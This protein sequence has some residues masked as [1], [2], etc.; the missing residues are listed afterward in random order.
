M[1]CRQHAAAVVVGSSTTRSTARVSPSG[2][3][4]VNGL[5]LALVTVAVMQVR[6]AGHAEIAELPPLLHWLRDAALALPLALA[7]VSV[8]SWL[9]P[10]AHRAGAPISERGLWVLTGGAVWALSSVPAA[11]AHGLLF[12]EHSNHGLAKHGLAMHALLEGAAVLGVAL[13]LLAV[14]AA[15]E[16]LW[17]TSRSVNLVRAVNLVRCRAAVGG[18]GASALVAGQL[19]VAVVAPTPAA[20]S[21][22][23]CT[24]TGADRSYDVTAATVDI[25][26]NR[27]GAHVQGSMF[28][29]S[30]DL[31]AV[32]NWSVPLAA[33]PAADVAGGRRLRPRPLVLRANAGECV[34]V[35]LHNE[36]SAAA[37]A[38]MP[39]DPHVSIHPQGVA[40]NVDSDGSATG[41]NPDSTVALHGTRTYLWTAPSKEGMYL[42][43]DFGVPGGAEHDAGQ[44]G[45]G[46]FGALNVEPAGSRWFDP[47]SGAELSLPGSQVYGDAKTRAQSGEL[48]VDAD[49]V[50]PAPA[51]TFR[52]STQIAQDEIPGVG[53]GFNYGS[54]PLSNRE[55][56]RCPD[57][58]GEETWL[59]SWPYGDPALIKLASGPGPWIPKEYGAASTEGPNGPEDCGLPESC[60]VSNVFHAYNSD[61]VKIRFGLAGVKETHVFHLHAHQWLAEPRDVG[62]MTNLEPSEAAM[63]ESNTVDSQSFASGEAYTAEL[64]FGSGSK[65]RTFG[66][67]I[68][69]C[70]LYPHFAEGFW[71]LYR[72]HDKREEGRAAVSA[73]PDLS[74]AEK[75]SLSATPDGIYVRPLLPLGSHDTAVAGPAL[76]LPS[77]TSPGFPRMIP[78]QYGWRAPQPLRG[79]TQRDPATGTEVDAPRYVAGAPIPQAQLDVEQAVSLA[80]NGGATAP[81]GAPYADPCPSTSRKVRYDVTVLQRDIVYNERGDHDP[82]G[83]MLVLTKD[84]PAILAGTKKAEP[85]FMRVNAGDCVDYALTDMLPNFV[86]NDD[87]L[88]LTQTNMFGQHIHL[89][90]FDVT[91]SDG[92]SNGWNYQEAAFTKDQVAFDAKAADPVQHDTVCKAE[93]DTPGVGG[94][95]AGCRIPTPASWDPHT[96]SDSMTMTG[97]TIHERWYADYELRTIFTHDHH[98]AAIDQSRGLYGSLIVEPRGSDIRDPFSGQYLQPINDPAHGI[99]C[100]ALPGGCEGDAVGTQR[101]VVGQGVADDF[102]E[103]ALALADF[104]TLVK[105]DPDPVTGRDVP[106]AAPGKPEHFPQADPGTMA[107]NYRNAPLRYRLQKSGVD[108][109]PAYRMSSHVFGDP[110]TPLLQAYGGDPVRYRVIQGSQEEQHE[111]MVNGV[112]WKQ[113]PDDPESPLVNTATFGISEAFNME[114]PNIG[115]AADDDVCL[116]DYLYSSAS[117]DDTWNGMWG[118][119]RVHG[120]KFS[121]FLELPDHPVAATKLK[122]SPTPSGTVPASKG[123]GDPCPTS[124]PRRTFDVVALSRDIQYDEQ[125]DHDPDGMIYALASDP[126]AADPTKRPRPLALHATEGDCIEVTLTNKLDPA[127]AHRAGTDGDPTLVQEDPTGE[128][129]GT[130]VSL[131]PQ[132]VRYDVRGS[133]GATVGYNPD[134][135]VAPGKSYTYRWYADPTSPGEIGGTNLLDFG[136]LRGHRHHG[137]FAGLS[138]APAGSTFHN[139]YTG[140]SVSAG[141]A[142]DVRTA[143]GKGY[144]DFSQFFQDGLN[145]RDKAGAWIPDAKAHVGG[146][147]EPMDTE[148]QGKKGLN[149][150]TAMF[151]RRLGYDPSLTVPQT[152]QDGS[153][154]TSDEW[155]HVFSTNA[156]HGDP[157]TPIFRSYAGDAVRMHVLQGGDK[158]RGHSFYLSGHAWDR[159]PGDPGTDLTSS[160]G[161]ISVG[162]NVEVR[163]TAAGRGDWRFGCQVSFHHLSG[164]LWGILRVYD[165][166]VG[167]PTFTPNPVSA[168]DD[169]AG[170]GGTPLQPLDRVL[171]RVSAYDDSNDN[172]IRDKAE[173]PL[174]GAPVGLA[175]AVG[176]Q[177]PATLTAPP[178]NARTGLDGTAT[179]TVAA[180]ATY[181]VE[182]GSPAASWVSTTGVQRVSTAAPNREFAVTGAQVK[183]ADI[184]VRLYDDQNGDQVAGPGEPAVPDGWT[185]TLTGAAS[186]TATTAGGLVTFPGL[187]PGGY[188]ATATPTAGWAATGAV[189]VHVDLVEGVSRTGPAGPGTGQVEL[190]YARPKGLTVHVFN[191]ADGDGSQGPGESSIPGAAV[192]AVGPSVPPVLSSDLNGN[193]TF[194]DLLPGTYSVSFTKGDWSLSGASATRD[195]TAVTV[196]RSAGTASL[197]ILSPPPGAGAYAYA[198]VLA[199]SNP[200]V[201]VVARPFNDL[202]ADGARQDRDGKITGW[203]TVLRATDGTNTWTVSNETIGNGGSY[204]WYVPALPAGQR[205]VVKVVAPPPSLDPD[206]LDWTATT[207]PE[208]PMTVARGETGTAEH[209]F[210]QQGTVRAYLFN[211][212]NK[213]RVFTAEEPTQLADRQ[214]RLFDATGKTVLATKYT[215]P[216]GSAAFKVT[217]GV[218]YQVQGVLPT[219]WTA[220]APYDAK[221]GALS[222]VKFVAPLNTKESYPVSFGQYNTT[223]NV[224]PA[225]PTVTSAAQT[226]GSLL[227]SMAT[228]TGGKIRYTVDLQ[229]ELPNGD[230]ST[231]TGMVY[232][233]PVK[234][235][236]GR[237]LKVIAIDSAGNTS[238]VKTVPLDP[239]ATSGKVLVKSLVSPTSLTKTI[240]GLVTG[241]ISGLKTDEDGVRIAVASAAS[242]NMQVVDLSVSSSIPSTTGLKALTIRYDGGANATGATRALYMWSLTAKA[243]KQLGASEAQP[244][245]ESKSTFDAPGNGLEFVGPGNEVRMRLRVAKSVAFEVRADQFVA[246]ATTAP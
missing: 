209:G 158:S 71:S 6:H 50:P 16:G 204:T 208:V 61:P 92:A 47:R 157:W 79:I 94:Q 179:L 9:V 214:V 123:P 99:V 130:R 4:I 221:L 107:I 186:R 82:Q 46:A 5:L 63:P 81:R 87:F 139:P 222:K 161:G 169:P 227:V 134:Q 111:F 120:K 129:T 34:A 172:G 170:P 73:R 197:D 52:E 12:V 245:A 105:K 17:R 109:D 110:M 57:C 86:G 237:T 128:A 171:L 149:Y 74:A 78:G 195:G 198:A 44:M 83:R 96:Q 85:L 100:T 202:N 150:G 32:K 104:V 152:H 215:G 205:Y 22:T 3:D 203:P 49:I 106:I 42:F 244:A 138:I 31:A 178:V 95:H 231:A 102:R 101:D 142:V 185:V 28:I 184:G 84:V 59:S 112:R 58:S 228:E 54:E 117:T 200:N 10:A 2:L 30:Q 19:V 210:V 181:D 137:L 147:V 25:P 89:V 29:L 145:L 192:T 233:A 240:G 216:D 189:P 11:A 196:V 38:G 69:H 126:T 56:Y 62:A 132:L 97:Q 64:L 229:P 65:N 148:D 41:Y 80:A 239:P 121:G 146:P 124:A 199:G 242:G 232:S 43:R 235:T 108:V 135:T 193:V 113:E 163:T 93:Y 223:D 194:V 37:H 236:T 182:V 103:F 159:Q 213:D 118:L 166:P 68:F 220:T 243:W 217:A 183:L 241:D 116:G 180:N 165:P 8:A 206:V 90:K 75:Q 153:P 72:V 55:K 168:I 76:A 131:H 39:A 125:G 60:Y 164:G 127:Y 1:A 119:M 160:Q 115:C 177:P 24:Q 207:Q 211:D 77:A 33:D 162:R 15:A 122:A 91:S 175:P 70:H 13:P 21:V 201:W 18:L 234:V 14:L 53:L 36:L 187:K 155:A 225:A 67:V 191:D 246:L 7:A 23:S 133:D 144:R 218:T 188:D 212:W 190:G 174:V 151:A 167:S 27:W 35:T 136:D 45:F 48:Y 238:D 143:D 176:A 98:F 66:D 40:Y 88:E 226:D 140:E 51:K 26:Y 156:A 20:A 141:T 173:Q 154:L 219:G 230:P 224:P 114:V